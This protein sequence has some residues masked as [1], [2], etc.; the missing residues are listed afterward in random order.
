MWQCVRRLLCVSQRTIIH[1]TLHCLFLIHFHTCFA[2]LT[3]CLGSDPTSQPPSDSIKALLHA[4]LTACVLRLISP[5]AAYTTGQVYTPPCAALTHVLVRAVPCFSYS[6]ATW[7]SSVVFFVWLL[8]RRITVA[9]AQQQ[10]L[11]RIAEPSLREHSSTCHRGHCMTAHR[12]KKRK[13]KN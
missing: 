8:N 2:F 10:R 7:F 5:K 1:G 6:A 4:M 13:K 11:I 3:V 12:E 9:R